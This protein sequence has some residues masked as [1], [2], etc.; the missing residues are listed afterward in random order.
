MKLK[1]KKKNGDELF[2]A[3]LLRHFDYYEDYKCN[4]YEGDQSNEEIADAEDLTTH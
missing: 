2:Y 1:R 3:L 4:D